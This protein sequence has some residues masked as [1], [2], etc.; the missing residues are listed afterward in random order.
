MSYLPKRWPGPVAPSDAHLTGIQGHGFHT[1]VQQH[2]F[3]EIFC[4]HSLH[5]A[6]PS[7]AVVS[8][9]WKEVH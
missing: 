9:W 8:Y 4:G 7:I 3:V 5:I 6:D 1:P 2:S